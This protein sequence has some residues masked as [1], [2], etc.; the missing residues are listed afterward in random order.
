MTDSIAKT[1]I[2]INRLLAQKAALQYK[3]KKQENSKRKARTRTLIQLGGLLDLTPL[4]AICKIELGEDL[5][6]DHPDK[7]ATLLGM[8]SYF[9]DQLPENLTDQDLAKFKSVGENFLKR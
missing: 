7:S 1:K 8:L 2:K 4:L 5:Q 6:I 3:M 9:S